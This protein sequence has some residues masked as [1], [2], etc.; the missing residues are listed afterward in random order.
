MKASRINI[1]LIFYAAGG[2][3]PLH[4]Q[5]ALAKGAFAST[6]GSTDLFQYVFKALDR[7]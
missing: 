4:R 3:I 2:N 5:E 6:N 7:L 1:P